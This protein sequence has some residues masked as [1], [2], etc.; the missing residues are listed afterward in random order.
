MEFKRL[1]ASTLEEAV[2]AWNDGFEGYYFNATM[3]LEAFVKRMV[4]EELSPTLSIVAFKDNQPAGIVMSGIREVGGRKIAWN[5]GT[6]LA[7]PLRGAGHGRTLMEASIAALR[8]EGAELST[9]E[10]LSGNTKA[11][12]LYERIGYKIV[13]QLE[14]L[15]LKGALESSPL[16]Q[17]ISGYTAVQAA[18]VQVGELP[19]YKG[20][21]P[22]QTHW[23]NARD[24]EAVIVR[25]E[26]GEAV[27]YAYYRKIYSPEGIHTGT[28]LFQCEAIP[29]YLQGEGIIQLLL[30]DIFGDFSDDIT[31]MVPNLPKQASARTD[32]VLRQTGFTTMVSQVQMTMEL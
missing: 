18:A 32:A 14:H 25:D 16:P 8:E 21:N 6:G 19:F 29:G 13:D 27:G 26:A 1:S 4:S 9:L 7:L 10:A 24:G 23:Q 28:T 2:Q 15:S 11:I 20:G 5:G 31:R 22:W 17:K 3:T 30:W 12:T